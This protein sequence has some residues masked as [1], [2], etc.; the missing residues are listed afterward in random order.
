MKETETIP[1]PA[2]LPRWLDEIVSNDVCE[3]ITDDCCEVRDKL[4]CFM[5]NPQTGR[6]PFLQGNN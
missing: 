6:C 5:H 1:A 4:A 2:P 3:D